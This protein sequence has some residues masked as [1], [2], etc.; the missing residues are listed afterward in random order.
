[1]FLSDGEEFVRQGKEERFKRLNEFI[2]RIPAV[3]LRLLRLPCRWCDEEP[4]QRKLRVSWKH[5]RL[6]QNYVTPSYQ[7]VSSGYLTGKILCVYFMA[8]DS[9]FVSTAG[10][11]CIIFIF[12]QIWA[13]DLRP[14]QSCFDWMILWV[15]RSPVFFS[16]TFCS[17]KATH[18]ETAKKGVF[19]FCIFVF[20][21]CKWLIL[22]R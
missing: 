6:G 4:W 3:D 9:W 22:W 16:Q 5:P 15:G 2:T 14:Q 20:L 19:W 1:M 13:F 17:L 18:M 11:N 8:C 12:T 21:W 10:E 7:L